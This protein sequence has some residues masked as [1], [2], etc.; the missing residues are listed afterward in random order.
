M[1]LQL[2]PNRQ[3]QQSNTIK[4]DNDDAF[5]AMPDGGKLSIMTFR[6]I[7]DSVITVADTALAFHK[8]LEANYSRR[9]LQPNRRGK[10]LA[11]CG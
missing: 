10:A 4:D 3:L 2:G 6:D 8:R 9:C 7:E 1:M 5:Q 11:C